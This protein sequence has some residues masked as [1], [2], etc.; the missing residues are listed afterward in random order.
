MSIEFE[1]GECRK[2]YR[3]ADD[4]AGKHVKCKQCGAV[5]RVPELAA[6]H[7]VQTMEP[8][9]TIPED[10]EPEAEPSPP[11]PPG[12]PFVADWSRKILDETSK[13]FVGQDELVR[14]VSLQVH[15]RFHDYYPK[16]AQAA[17]GRTAQT[18]QN[19]YPVVYPGM[20]ERRGPRTGML[21]RDLPGQGVVI[22][23]I[24]NGSP[25]T[26]AFLIAKES[27]ISLAPQQFVVS[28]NG[29]PVAKV[30][31]APEKTMCDDPAYMAYLRQVFELPP[32]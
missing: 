28:V 17:K 15:T 2:H 25:A 23:S 24:E 26:Q 18:Q 13:V 1:C 22:A 27:F 32:A 19:V 14:G 10:V 7:E 16:G 31:D 8:F 21:V 20:P 5:V 4:M 3:V 6:V 29:Q 11:P 12:N 30:S 9:V